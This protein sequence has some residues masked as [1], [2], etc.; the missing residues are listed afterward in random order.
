MSE[1]SLPPFKYLDPRRYPSRIRDAAGRLISRLRRDEDRGDESDTAN[2]YPER[3][4]DE[5][6]AENTAADTASSGHAPSVPPRPASGDGSSG[7]IADAARERAAKVLSEHLRKNAT[8][9]D[10]AARM[11]DQAERLEREGIPSDSARN[12]AARAREDVAEG[13]ARLR[14]AMI[15]SGEEEPAR[16]LDLEVLKL[17]PPIQPG[18]IR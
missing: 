15:S 9:L 1:G 14:R 2:T 10:R 18:E 11:R 8:N 3:R 16:A 7:E 5:P 12:R 13:I 6:A 4:V 17:D